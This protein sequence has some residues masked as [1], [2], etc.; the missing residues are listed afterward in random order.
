MRSLHDD[1][2]PTRPRA[3]LAC[4]LPRMAGH[5]QLVSWHTPELGSVPQRP[6][7]YEDV[8]VAAPLYDLSRMAAQESMTW[9]GTTRLHDSYR[10]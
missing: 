1:N 2:E 8:D 9:Y 7:A 5:D 4:L 10:D 3:R 6:A